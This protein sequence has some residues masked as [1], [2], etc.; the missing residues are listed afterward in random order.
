MPPFPG[1]CLRHGARIGGA[2][3]RG[4]LAWDHP[5]RLMRIEGFARTSARRAGRRPMQ[6]DGSYVWRAVAF[7][8]TGFGQRVLFTQAGS[9]APSTQVAW[10][11][12]VSS[13][14]TRAIRS[15]TEKGFTM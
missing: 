7:W 8:R 12:L 15:L 1:H 2:E 11:R 13:T 5:H 14:S 10:V 9:A 6:S 3:A 4:L